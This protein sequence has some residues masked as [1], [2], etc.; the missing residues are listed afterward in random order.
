MVVAM[1]EQVE[2]EEQNELSE[3]ERGAGGFG[4]TG[5]K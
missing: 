3:S 5:V 1:H 2:W 4:S